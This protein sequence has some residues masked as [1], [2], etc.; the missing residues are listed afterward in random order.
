MAMAAPED[1]DEIQE[2]QAK[3]RRALADWDAAGPGPRDDAFAQVVPAADALVAAQ[4]H[5]LRRRAEVKAAL[6]RDWT[7]RIMLVTAAVLVG[8]LLLAGAS[9]WWTLLAVPLLA[10]GI[11]LLISRRNRD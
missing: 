1:H 9:P 2:L 8:A 6:L 5:Q 11:H 4:Q 10:A 7:G 3:L